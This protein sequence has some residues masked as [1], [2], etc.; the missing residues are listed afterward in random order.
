MHKYSEHAPLGFGEVFKCISVVENPILEP[1]SEPQQLSYNNMTANTDNGYRAFASSTAGNNWYNEE[2]L[3]ANDPT[4]NSATIDYSPSEAYGAFMDIPEELIEKGYRCLGCLFD[5]SDYDNAYIGQQLPTAAAANQYSFYF[6][7]RWC[8]LYYHG[9]EHHEGDSYP[10]KEWWFEGSNNGSTWTTLHHA[11]DMQWTW[12]KGKYESPIFSNDT[13]YTHY[14]LRLHQ[15][16]SWYWYGVALFKFYH[17]DYRITDP[18]IEIVKY[19][20]ATQDF[21]TQVI[22]KPLPANIPVAYECYNKEFNIPV[23]L[24]GRDPSLFLRL[25]YGSGHT[26]KFTG[27]MAKHCDIWTAET[28][29]THNNPGPFPN[30]YTFQ[31]TSTAR[32]RINNH[33]NIM[34]SKL[35]GDFTIEFW[36]YQTRTDRGVVIQF[37]LDH[38]YRLLIDNIDQRWVPW[39]STNGGGWDVLQGDSSYDAN[40][41]IDSTNSRG[42]EQIAQNK[43]QHVAFVHHG[44]MWYVFVDGILSMIRNREGT[45]YQSTDGIMIGRGHGDGNQ[46]YGRLYDLRIWTI[47]KYTVPAGTTTAAQGTKFFTPET[48]PAI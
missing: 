13:A 26:G 29:W 3:P 20:A 47:A 19:K 15:D 40:A 24:A 42:C 8:E 45:W 46:W 43:W 12:R 30:T 4:G 1:I 17:V 22:R 14:R 18:Y 23:D 41:A 16:E 9:E 7:D 38:N 6:P 34:Q 28:N 27:Q 35:A 2:S 10:L 48:E 5:Y 33:N 32:W 44:T 21:N 36:A 31:I 39:V 37:D 11:T 25:F